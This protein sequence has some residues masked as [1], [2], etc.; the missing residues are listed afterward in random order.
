MRTSKWVSPPGAAPACP[1]C[2]A[3]SSETLMSDG[4]NASVNL[5]WI[6]SATAITGDFA[7]AAGQSQAIRFLVFSLIAPI[8]LSMTGTPRPRFK[9]D[10]RINKKGTAAKGEPQTTPCAVTGWAK[11]GH[12]RGPKS[13]E[14]LNEHQFLCAAHARAFNESWDFFKGMSDDDIIKFREEAATGH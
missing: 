9:S 1:A 14:N 8:I 10:I 2:R 12:C 3:L 6:E 7:T 11:P 13:R 5:R 4:A